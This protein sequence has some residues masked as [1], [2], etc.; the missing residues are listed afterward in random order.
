MNATVEELQARKKELD[1]Q[2]REVAK[3][4]RIANTE[5]GINA[6]LMR[7]LIVRANEEVR[8]NWN[9][10][11]TA[12]RNCDALAEEASSV[13]RKLL[14]DWKWQEEMCDEEKVELPI[15]HKAGRSTYAF[16]LHLMVLASRDKAHAKWEE[17]RS[18]ERVLQIELS[19]QDP[20]LSGLKRY[21]FMEFLNGMNADVIKS[22][23]EE[24]ALTCNFT[25][26]E[27]K[28]LMDFYSN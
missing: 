25:K 16:A 21:D 10:I 24:A 12:S 5:K 9:E 7:S 11:V 27:Y 3:Q 1:K 28:R 26:S 15:S 6:K 18:L 13:W 19:A 2:A 4:I 17:I 22:L 20:N 8:F 23:P 14:D